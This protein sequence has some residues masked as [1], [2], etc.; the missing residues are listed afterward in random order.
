MLPSLAAHLGLLLVFDLGRHL[1][2]ALVLLGLAFLS[3]LVAARRL[4]ARIPITGGVVLLGVLALRLPLLAIPPTLSDDVLRYLWDGKVA[5]SGANPYALPPDAAELAPLRDDA[6]RRLPHRQVATVYPPL[7]MAAFSIAARLP[8]PSLV[9][10]L[11]VVA[12][13]LGACALLLALARRLGV[14][15]GRT[16]WYAWN[17]LVGLETA[18]MGHVDVLGVAATLGAVLLLL[19]PRRPL[20]AGAATAAGVL[21]KLAPAAALPMWSRQSGRPAAFLLAALG[22]SAVALLPVV[23]ATGGLPPGL[24]VYGVSWEF[25]GPLHE[26]LWRL[27]D[28]VDA[29]R[30]AAG[31]LDR[32]K[33]L[34]GWHDL[35]NRLYPYAYPQLLSK[36]VLAAGAAAALVASLKERDPAAGTGRLFGRLLLVSATVHPWYLL[37]V[38]PWAALARH[39][40]WLALSATVLLAYLPQRAGVP[41]VPWVYL[42]IWAPF[43]LLLAVGRGWD[44]GWNR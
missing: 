1:V 41:L 30:L 13:D 37:W 42:A 23:V 29:D 10:K 43:A 9:W 34:T 8:F 27:L 33:W 12:A 18:G 28:A 31:A 21:A 22:L 16:V 19:P 36:M 3:L 40:A 32:L 35:W 17:P 7:A 24:L 2:T 44:R 11:A 6:W 38:L 4:E 15:P 20:G 26:P 5:A 14:P 39:T 25:N